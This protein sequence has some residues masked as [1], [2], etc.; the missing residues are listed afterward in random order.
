MANI[1]TRFDDAAFDGKLQNPAPLGKLGA[2]LLASDL[3]LES[4]L[5]QMLPKGI[6]I[7]TNRVLNHNPLTMENLRSMRGDIQRAAAG[8]IPG[9][10]MDAVIYGC[11]SGTAA[12]GNDEVQRLIHIAHPLAK[13]IT[14]ITAVLAACRAMKIKRLSILT[15]YIGEINR[16]MAEVFTAQGFAPVNIAAMAIESDVDAAQVPMQT[17]ISMA[18]NAIDNSAD[19]LFI[20][21]T[22]LPV[23]PLISQMESEFN[24]PVISSN[25]TLAWAV[26]RALGCDM[27]VEGFG[28]LMQRQWQ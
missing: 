15:P 13:V 12:I 26:L 6:G 24:I 3:T 9:A 21:C 19:A 8:I 22:S 20:S 10:Q 23:A 11:T 2:L 5:H 7:Y 28:K 4:E 16:A 1:K 17:L 27:I 18:Q 25:Q 14:P